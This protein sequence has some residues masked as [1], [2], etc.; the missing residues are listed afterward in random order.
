[1]I[2]E[3]FAR[4]HPAHFDA[5]NGLKRM[6]VVLVQMWWQSRRPCWVPLA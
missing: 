3:K 4:D 2:V 6:P 1:M 5:V